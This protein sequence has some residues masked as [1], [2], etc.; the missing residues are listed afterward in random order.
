[1][2]LTYSTKSVNSIL[3][4]SS[5]NIISSSAGGLVSYQNSVMTSPVQAYVWKDANYNIIR[6]YEP[7]RNNEV[8]LHTFI[9]S[10]PFDN[11]NCFD[12]KIYDSNLLDFGTNLIIERCIFNNIHIKAHGSNNIIL[13]DN[14]FNGNLGAYNP[15]F[16]LTYG[17]I[18]FRGDNTSITNSIF[19]GG[20]RIYFNS[21]GQGTIIRSSTFKKDSYIDFYGCV[22]TNIDSCSFE[23][24][25]GAD[26]YKNFSYLQGVQVKE[27]AYI[28]ITGGIYF[29]TFD[30]N[31]YC[32]VGN[33]WNAQVVTIVNA[34]TL[35]FNGDLNG[36]I[37][38]IAYFNS[39]NYWEK[40]NTVNSINYNSG[41]NTT[42]VSFQ[43]NVYS[44]IAIGD[45]VTFYWGFTNINSI[46]L[47]INGNLQCYGLDL[48]IQNVTIGNGGTWHP[49]TNNTLQLVVDYFST[50]PSTP[51]TEDLYN[52]FVGTFKN[53]TTGDTNI[54]INDNGVIKPLI[55]S[56]GGTTTGATSYSK[57][58]VLD[59]NFNGSTGQGQIGVVTI[60]SFLIKSGWF[61]EEVFINVITTLTDDAGQTAS[62]TVGFTGN[63]TIG[64]NATTGLISTLNTD[65][66]TK[67]ELGTFIKSIS[68]TNVITVNV[69]VGNI[70]SGEVKLLIRAT[71][72]DTAISGDGIV[73]STALITLS[74][75]GS[76]GAATLV[77]TTLNI[78]NYAGGGGGQENITY[79]NL[80]TK[81]NNNT[82][83]AG[84]QYKITDFATIHYL[85][86]GNSNQDIATIFT[87]DNEPLIVTATST[88]KLD[89]VAYSLLFPQDTIYYDFSPTR[90]LLD[91]SFGDITTDSNNPTIIP[92]FKGVIY[93]RHDTVLDNYMGYD[94]RNV[95][96]RRWKSNIPVYDATASYDYGAV[97]K[98]GTN[99]FKA[100][101]PSNIFQTSEIQVYNGSSSGT[102]TITIAGITSTMT[103][104]TDSFQSCTDW[105]AANGATYLAL[106]I[107]ITINASSS[108]AQTNLVLISTSN[109]F[110]FIIQIINSGM[111]SQTS[112]FL[113]S[114]IVISTNNNDYWIPIID[115]TSNEYFITRSNGNNFSGISFPA[116]TVDFIDVKTFAEGTGSATYEKCCRNNHFETFKDDYNYFD[117][118]ATILIN[119]VFYLKDQNY[120]SVYNNTFGPEIL[121]NTILGFIN[122]N[123]ITYYFNNNIIGHNF[124]NNSFNQFSNNIVA[125][126]FTTNRNSFNFNS[127]TCGPQ[128]TNNTFFDNC[129]SNLL[130]DNFGSNTCDANFSVNY[131]GSGFNNNTIGKTFSS[132]KIDKYFNNNIVGNNCNN[133]KIKSY[134]SYNNISSGFYNN[135]IGDNFFSNS[136][137]VNFDSN[138]ISSDF[139]YNIIANEFNSNSIGNNFNRNSI[140]N[141]FSHNTIGNYFGVNTIGDSFSSNITISNFNSVTAMRN[142]SGINFTSSTIVYQNGNK[143]LFTNSG[144]TVR[145]S[146]YNSTDILT[147][148]DPTT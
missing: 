77:G 141:F 148:T 133:N 124:S 142:I 85:V 106:G 129:Y 110:D 69:G 136:L 54:Y 10:F 91:Q 107:A 128:T 135:N 49:T 109:T 119:T 123:N 4:N 33:S 62:L 89:K 86:D 83:S 37:G 94:F 5:G 139:R 38:T 145:L 2:A 16:S 101:K 75:A 122:N 60:P 14:E 18:D 45:N 76:T 35:E 64:L 134:S 6:I 65:V 88:N 56:G 3:A 28:D 137:S 112:T 126:Y 68:D 84:K 121:G 104:N 78:P 47:G 12:N 25:G 100:I 59:I 15:T 79:A 50:K 147:I 21:I 20:V 40:S 108:T 87:G 11:L 115:L 95:K 29:C 32:G 143:T 73:N 117:N 74:T 8:T 71:N 42:T 118:S 93:F 19:E 36:H 1:M 96:Y 81:V 9:D 17:E 130:A 34:N 30:K 99:I 51:T 41:T 146:Y 67:I 26:I 92:G 43:N 80:V 90:W 111:Y 131:I 27:N 61:I 53:T 48:S 55:T 113:T 103:F 138:T 13:K 46:E 140:G 144:N 57:D 44:A 98:D 58:Y 102:I 7:L 52:G 125:N 114:S 22:G 97:V 82:L 24:A 132:N 31:S 116:L 70:V 63:D 66:N 127:N 39:S 105:Y 23:F 72:Y 120:Y